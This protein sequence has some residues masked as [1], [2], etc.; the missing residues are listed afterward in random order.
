MLSGGILR[1][2]EPD[3]A[4]ALHAAL[5]ILDPPPDEIPEWAVTP[6]TLAGHCTR[7]LP[8][9]M[10]DVQRPHLELIDQAYLDVAAGLEDRVL[11]TMPPRHGKTQRASHWGPA[12]YLRRFPD[13][14]VILAAHTGEYALEQGRRVR[15]II[16]DNRDE[17]PVQ[18]RGDSSAASRWNLIGRAGGMT[19]AGIGGPITG[20][21]AHLL[22]I[23]DPIK[24]AEEAHSSTIREKHWDWY[25]STALTRLEPGGAVILILCMTGGTPV[26]M[27]DG[28][29]KPLRDIRPGDAVATYENGRIST[30]VVRNWANQGPDNIYEIRMKSGVSVRANARHPFLTVENGAEKWQRTDTLRPGS[31][32]LR[33]IGASGATSSAP[34]TDATSPRSARA[35]AC[36]T[37]TRLDGRPEFDLPLSIP[38]LGA[39]P[40]S[41]T[42]TASLPRNMTVASLSRAA[43][44]PSVDSLRRL[45]ICAPT[46]MGSSASITTTRPASCAACSAT[47]ATSQSGTGSLPKDSAPPLTT[48]SVTPDEVLEVVPVGVEDVYDIQVDRTENFIANGLVSHNTRWHEDD[49]AGRLLA[50]EADEWHVINLPALAEAGDPLGR[51]P[52]EALWPERYDRPALLRRKKTIGSYW[53]SALFQ[54]R[55]SPAE[56]GL[57]KKKHMRFWK[58]GPR[59]AAGGDLRPTYD[60]GGR[61][62]RDIDCWRFMTVDLAASTKTSADWTVAAVWAV[63]PA[64]DLI[65]LDRER[66][67]L[68]EGDHWPLVRR[69]YERYEVDWVGVESRMFGTKL[70]YGAGQAGVPLRELIADTDKVTRAIPASVRF[71]QG[72]LWLP[73]EG[74]VSW[75]VS[76]YTDELLAFPNGRHD[77]QVD[78]T[79]YAA[80]VLATAGTNVASIPNEPTDTVMGDLMTANW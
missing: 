76:E 20:R 34:Q 57:F 69:L 71:E 51:Q 79:A 30:S 23:D 56:G 46:G 13:R 80:L 53:F 3:P 7:N 62:V 19:T 54:Q 41:S 8:P 32:I 6:G 27:A 47:T 55:P 78:V 75:P 63:T 25:G 12:W 64:G 17:F 39:L 29:E 40:G 50:K 52:G 31:R 16:R 15:D 11:I 72:R 70:V 68:D 35:C 73:A 14:R 26:L 5:D 77:D 49:L 28:S 45:G 59:R 22:V 44:A 61:I 24:D 43:S 36:R 4:E 10:Q 2:W 33:A 66:Q 48:W 42:G 1:P 58:A 60:L 21:G 18:I 67:R 37:T 74:A 38:P 65:L 9:A